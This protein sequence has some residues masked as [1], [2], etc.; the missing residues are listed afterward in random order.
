M[1]KS[2]PLFAFAGL[3]EHWAGVDG[4]ELETGLIITTGPNR[5]AAPIHDRMPVII[6]PE[7]HETWLSG[8]PGAALSLIRPAPDDFLIAE[9]T[10]I[11][12]VA[13]VRPVAPA[14][15]QGSLL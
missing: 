8:E 15:G 14:G 5:V 6:A 2:F 4:A 3:W 1:K 13:P 9:E 7:D 12:R 10:R 11:E